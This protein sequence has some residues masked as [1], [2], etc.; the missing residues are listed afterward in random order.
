MASD[1]ALLEA[2]REQCRIFGPRLT[3]IVWQGQ[4]CVE[5]DDLIDIVNE[6]E[7]ENK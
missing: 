3:L 5:N 7:S 1:P 2:F 6:M 4:A